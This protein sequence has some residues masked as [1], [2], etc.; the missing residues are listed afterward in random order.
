MQNRFGTKE[1]NGDRWIKKFRKVNH[2]EKEKMFK[3]FLAD[4]AHCLGTD[5]LTLLATDRS[6]AKTAKLL[7]LEKDK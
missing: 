2:S 4:A 3:E 6:L 1:F 5:E 7:L